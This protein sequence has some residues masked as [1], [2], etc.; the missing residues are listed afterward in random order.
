MIHQFHLNK[1]RYVIIKVNL[2]PDEKSKQWKRLMH[3]SDL[4]WS[5]SNLGFEHKAKIQ[6]VSKARNYTNLW[7]DNRVFY[8]MI[9]HPTAV[10]YLYPNA[11]LMVVQQH[12]TVMV[13]F[14]DVVPVQW[15]EIL[16][17]LCHLNKG[18]LH[19]CDDFSTLNV[20]CISLSCVYQ[21]ENIIA[22]CFN[23]F[24][25][26]QDKFRSRPDLMQDIYHQLHICW[27]KSQWWLLILVVTHFPFC[28][29]NTAGRTGLFSV[30]NLGAKISHW[31]CS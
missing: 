26:S 22:F 7:V 14:D 4:L 28:V 27:H 24:L 3:L 16:S 2:S 11:H 25:L 21:F 15:S 6:E 8:S 9:S 13:I 1:T 29:W 31:M 17:R 12:I 23:C 20:W 18:S 5:C 19:V 10:S 30:G